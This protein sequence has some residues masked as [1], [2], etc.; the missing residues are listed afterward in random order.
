MAVL[1]RRYVRDEGLNGLNEGSV[2]ARVSEGNS[3]DDSGRSDGGPFEYDKT[4][5]P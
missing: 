2:T 1:I 4:R 5:R 3:N